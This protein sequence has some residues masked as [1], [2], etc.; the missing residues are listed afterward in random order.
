MLRL[1]DAWIWDFWFADT[2]TEFH[3]FF[4]RASRALRDPMRRHRWASVG[5]AV[6]TDLRT[7]TLLPDALA[8]SDGPAW[9]DLAIWTGSVLRGPDGTWRMF[10]TALSRAEGGAVQRIGIAT[11]TDL[12]EWSAAAAPSVVSDPRW[13]EQLSSGV[14]DHEA[15]R[16]PWV[17]AD[18]GG[19]GWHML[20]T[21][22]SAGG[23][24]GERGV[25]GHAWSPDLERWEVGPPLSRPGSGFT[26]LEVMQTAVVDGRPVLL[27]SCL[28]SDASATR[29]RTAP[30]GGVWAVP[31][32]SVLGP[33]D[34]ARA[35][36]LLDDT[37][38][39]GRLVADRRG[40][41][42]LLAFHNRNDDDSFDG[43]LSDPMP[44][45]WRGGVLSVA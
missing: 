8:P 38:Y 6:S 12:I 1:P 14:R 25:V 27:F 23:E 45:R 21:A 40:R 26:H 29:R 4:L 11:S 28:A 24:L 31:C 33:F 42:Q 20:V 43:R 17:F 30:H 39:V 3:V 35:T 34:V 18:P 15:W 10:Y 19:D 7:W 13:Y 37:F 36:A 22:R 41:S 2:G 32:E 16:D 9:D 5:H 44:V